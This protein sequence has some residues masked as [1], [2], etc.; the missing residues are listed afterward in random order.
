MSASIFHQTNDIIRY[1]TWRYL[2]MLLKFLHL[3]LKHSDISLVLLESF[4]S[5][6]YI[7]KYFIYSC[8]LVELKRRI[9]DSLL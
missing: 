5:P 9:T 2:L 4:V 7:A 8:G 1:Q 3:H 6:C